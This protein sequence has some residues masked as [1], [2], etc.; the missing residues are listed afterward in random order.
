MRKAY[1]QELDLLAWFAEELRRDLGKG[2]RVAISPRQ[3][4]SPGMGGG[5]AKIRAPD[6]TEARLWIAAEP[7]PTPGTP[8][9]VA[10]FFEEAGAGDGDCEVALVL[11]PYLSPRLRAGCR[12][13]GLAYADRTGAWSLRLTRPS[14]RWERAGARKNPEPEGRGIASLRGTSTARVLR[15][16]I[17]YEPPFSLTELGEMARVTI[18]TAYKVVTLLGEEGL[19]E[20]EP[21]GEVLRVDWRG[22]IER[23][24]GEYRLER[25]NTVRRFLAPRGAQQAWDKLKS[26][27]PEAECRSTDRWAVTGAWAARTQVDLLAAPRFVV[28]ATQ[29]TRLERVLEL[30]QS[31]EPE[32]NV[33]VLLPR[34]VRIFEEASRRDGVWCAP[35]SQVAIDLL[36]GR[37]REPSA[38]ENLLNWMEVNEP[39]WRARRKGAGS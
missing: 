37:D 12:R 18:P 2:W 25:Q 4:S 5:R 38:G 34:D 26:V 16:L 32:S 1:S 29:T 22:L 19:V 6:G 36:G 20:R 35:W 14:I 28:Y 17:D 27:E 9:R 13:L 31:A 39:R 3:T 11:A 23:W 24:A 15:A 33:A 10:Q 21:R 7:R 8:A 30:R